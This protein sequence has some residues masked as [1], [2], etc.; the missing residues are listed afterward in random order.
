[1]TTLPNSATIADFLN[2]LATKRNM[3]GICIK[4]DGDDVDRETHIRDLGNQVFDVSP[5][6][7]RNDV[8]PERPNIQSPLE[9]DLVFAID[10]T[11]SMASA[12]QA[13]HDRAFDFA[14]AFRLANRGLQL[15]VGCVCYR[16][17]VD[18]PEDGPPQCHALNPSILAFR[19]FLET[20]R[21]T[22]GGDAP[23]DWVGALNS[24]LG[25]EWRS[26]AIHAIVWIADAPAHGARY[27]GVANHQEEE[28]KFEPLVKR[29]VELKAQFFGLSIR[30]NEKTHGANRTFSE[31]EKIYEATG[32][33]FLCKF[34]EFSQ[35]GQ[36]GQTPADSAKTLGDAFSK[37]VRGLVKDVLPFDPLSGKGA[38]RP[39]PAVPLETPP[40]A[41]RKAGTVRFS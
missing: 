29:L 25:L 27:C 16:D 21:A 31:I 33:G 2:Y 35:T 12:I 30:P 15:Q 11:G 32:S 10:A 20:V 14:Q 6:P 34:Q 19:T 5:D 41:P 26:T 4:A 18:S 22:G 37:T 23:E 36:T 8:Q 7:E 1:M 3:V 13:A 24:L 28:P 40:P 39:G 38:T 17:P 9:L